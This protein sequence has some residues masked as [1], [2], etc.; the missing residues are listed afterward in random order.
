[1]KRQQNT[2][3]ECGFAMSVCRVQQIKEKGCCSDSVHAF[4]WFFR[5]PHCHPLLLITSQLSCLQNRL[6]R[7]YTLRTIDCLRI[8]TILHSRFADLL[9]KWQAFICF[10]IALCGSR[11]L[12]T[13]LMAIPGS[14]VDW[15]NQV[16]RVWL[17]FMRYI[18]NP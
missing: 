13:G 12:G 8:S 6:P 15:I 11:N 5:S 18:E 10:Q 9:L 7:I 14:L 3:K 16:S 17:C 2:T 4:R 1:V